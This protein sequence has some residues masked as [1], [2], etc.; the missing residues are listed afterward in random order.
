MHTPP[1]GGWGAG[2]GGGGGSGCVAVGAAA[3]AP[4]PANRTTA[5]VARITLPIDVEKFMSSSIFRIRP[6][7]EIPAVY[8]GWL[9]L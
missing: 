3:G 7:A 6:P 2:G 8:G 1:R 5:A 4:Q 9:V